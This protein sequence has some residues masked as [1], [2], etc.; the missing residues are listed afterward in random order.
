MSALSA[1]VLSAATTDGA[2]LF[3][4]GTV[5]GKKRKFQ[6]I[7]LRLGHAIL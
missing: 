6:S 2:K 5:F 3:Q 7:T 1:S 4:W